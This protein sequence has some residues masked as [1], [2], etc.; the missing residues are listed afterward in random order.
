MN[1]CMF[2]CMQVYI[3]VYEHV[4]KLVCMWIYLSIHACI[5]MYIILLRYIT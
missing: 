4:S 3:Y 1:L 5:N 2:K